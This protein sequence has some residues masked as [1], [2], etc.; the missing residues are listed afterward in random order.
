M[1]RPRS[2]SRAFT[3]IEVT[4]AIIILVIFFAIAGKI[5][6]SAVLLSAAGENLSDA[7]ARTDS[8]LYQ[9]RAD[10]WDSQ[11]ITVPDPHTVALVRSD[12]SQISWT[13]NPD[14]G[15][16][17]IGPTVTTEQWDAI[18]KEWTFSTDPVSLIIVQ[19]SEIPVRLVS[20]IL[21]AQR[22]QS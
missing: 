12:G 7:S 5:F 13:L 2:S 17:R 16:T 1:R 3:L 14:L 18:G 10:V 4:I 20:Q 6:N 8:A 11:S 9:L 19:K 15:L 22:T 21:L